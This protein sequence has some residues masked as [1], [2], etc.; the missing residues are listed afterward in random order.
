MTM[1]ILSLA[2]V[3]QA[4]II[5]QQHEAIQWLTKAKFGF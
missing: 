5:S 3:W 2:V 1:S 4:Q